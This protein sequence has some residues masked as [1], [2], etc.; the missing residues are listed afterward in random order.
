[1]PHYDRDKDEDVRVFDGG[2]DEDEAEGSHLPVVIIIAILVLAAFGGV[3]WLAYNQGVA[4]G[5]SD[6][7]VRVAA[8]ETAA[9]GNTSQIKVYQQQANSENE[10]TPAPAPVAKPQ[11][12]EPPAA[13]PQVAV[14]PPPAA[15]PAP[16]A[17]AAPPAAK[18]APAAI[19]A[20]PAAKPQPAAAKPVPAVVLD[21]PAG[22]A[23]KPPAQLGLVHPAPAAPPATAPAAKPAAMP[24]ASGGSYLLQIGAF[25]SQDEAMGAW[26]AYRGKHA[27]LLAGGFSP[28]VQRAD[29]GDK[30]VWY[31]LRIASF[32]D[33]A[34]A[35][36]LCD[37]L[38]AENG[39]CFLAH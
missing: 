19:A 36:A 30:G 18:P 24:A 17:T 13:P 21:K 22:P 12:A 3:V 1:M 34:S 9:P 38:K 39:N 16:A 20:P 33:K 2:E 4:R 27:A 31:R 29:L 28:D 7:P 15:K 32:A 6:V 5:R 35:A 37:K 25:K 14:A 23:T 10:E 8:A 11:A 26:K